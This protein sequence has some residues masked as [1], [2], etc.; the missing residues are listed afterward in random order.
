MEKITN[1]EEMMD[2]YFNFDYERFNNSNES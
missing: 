2:K 1:Y